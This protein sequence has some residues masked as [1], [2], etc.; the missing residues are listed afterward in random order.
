MLPTIKEAVTAAN[1]AR[2]AT[3]QMLDKTGAGSAHTLRSAAASIEGFADR[4]EKRF[5]AAS[6]I[7]ES[8]TLAP[9]STISAV[10]SA[11]IQAH[12]CWPP[13]P[14]PPPSATQPAPPK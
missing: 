8:T 6:D 10:W 13:P 1:D 12:S 5:T 7:V 9:C 14:S 4:T 2:D 11:A 3:A